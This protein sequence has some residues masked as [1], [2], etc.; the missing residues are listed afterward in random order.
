MILL[1]EKKETDAKKVVSIT[2]IVFGVVVIVLSLV[3]KVEIL[4]VAGVMFGG[5]YLLLGIEKLRKRTF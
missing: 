3:L 4:R 1:S 5:I 2:G